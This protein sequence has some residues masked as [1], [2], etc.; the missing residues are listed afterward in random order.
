[1]ATKKSKTEVRKR[2][3]SKPKASAK[4]KTKTVRPRP[5]A[6]ERSPLYTWLRLKGHGSITDL[7]RELGVCTTTI[8]NAA[9]LRAYVS[10]NVA[11]QIAAATGVDISTIPHRAYEI[12]G[13][14]VT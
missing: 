10:R 5:A 6:K 9:T 13:P 12:V 1:M 7:A 14:K 8:S 4:V 11:E 3:A 2:G